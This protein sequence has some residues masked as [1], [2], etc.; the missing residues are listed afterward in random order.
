MQN[1]FTTSGFKEDFW[2]TMKVCFGR[3]LKYRYETLDISTTVLIEC[4]LFR[5][6]IVEESLGVDVA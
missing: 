2:R 3:V 1:Y 6:F 5:F 4:H